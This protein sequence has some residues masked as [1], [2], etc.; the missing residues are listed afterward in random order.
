MY[1]RLEVRL[2]FLMSV[3]GAFLE[4]FV[5]LSTGP[6]II[7]NVLK[8]AYSPVIVGLQSSSNILYLFLIL[9]VWNTAGEIQRDRLRKCPVSSMQRSCPFDLMWGLWERRKFMILPM[10]SNLR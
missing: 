2:P 9:G 5:Y 1:I 10:L 8:I 6:V 4:I 3:V 7:R